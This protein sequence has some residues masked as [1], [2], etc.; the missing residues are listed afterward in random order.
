MVHSVPDREYL[1]P[2]WM[3]VYFAFHRWSG[4]QSAFVYLAPRLRSRQG[5]Y[6][7]TVRVKYLCHTL[8]NLDRNPL[9]KSHC[10][11][12]APWSLL[13]FVRSKFSSMFRPQMSRTM[14][15]SMVVAEPVAQG[16]FVSQEGRYDIFSLAQ[17]SV[18]LNHFRAR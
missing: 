7:N 3:T 4:W 16:S 14:C 13:W 6:R 15:P 17:R 5:A 12:W 1:M 10:G 18:I 2:T 11:N 8:Y 9:I